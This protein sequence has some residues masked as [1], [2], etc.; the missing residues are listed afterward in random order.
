M[1]KTIL[2][3]DRPTGCLHLG[4][5]IGSLENRINMQ[6]DFN[7]FIMVANVQ[8]LT[9]Y[10]DRP[11]L[12]KSQIFQVVEDYL[13]V[14]I[15]PDKSTIFVQSS[16]KPL[17]EMTV[18]FLNLVSLAR[19][20]QNP[21]IKDE[22]K[23]RGFK[24]SIPC[25]FLCYPISQAADITAFLADLVPVGKD[26]LPMIE[27]TNEIVDKFNSLYR[28]DVLKRC[29]AVLSSNS[30]LIGIDGKNKASKSLKN[31]IFLND[32]DQDLKDKIFSMYTD[33]AHIKVS[34]PGNVSENVVFKYLDAFYHDVSHLNDLKAH[35]SKGGLG[36]VYLKNLLFDVLKTFLEPIR[37]RRSRI[38]QTDIIEIISEGNKKASLIANNTLQKMQQVMCLV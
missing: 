37:E 2:T 7:T 29:E 24:E 8:A 36:D 35:Y 31:A 32:N 28:C 38:N 18:Y 22:I 15:D 13:A 19:A 11:E 12:I 14:G 3:G 17:F 26:Q 23:Q 33:P 5:Y 20:Q 25:G 4:H 10:Y 30:R 21:T 27:Q 16:V 9:D 34:D 1:M 6:H